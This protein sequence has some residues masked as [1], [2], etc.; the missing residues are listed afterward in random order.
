MLNDDIDHTVVLSATGTRNGVST[1]RR[2]ELSIGPRIT[3]NAAITT[4]GNLGGGGTPLR[5]REFAG[6]SIPTA[7]STNPASAER[8]PRGQPLRELVPGSTCT[9]S[10]A[11]EHPIPM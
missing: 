3:P 1:N 10:G 8:S 9:A 2:G 6:A 7:D 5:F 11:A 4:K